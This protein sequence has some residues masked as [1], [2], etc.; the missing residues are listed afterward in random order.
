MM[1]SNCRVTPSK[2]G[3]FDELIFPFRP[4]ARQIARSI[5]PH[6]NPIL[7]KRLMAE[8]LLVIPIKYNLES[9][10]PALRKRPNVSTVKST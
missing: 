1:H 2:F 4:A 3:L 8:K 7:P 9:S 6:L 10:M 5:P